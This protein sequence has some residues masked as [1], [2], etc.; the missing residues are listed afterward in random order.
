MKSLNKTNQL[1][2]I[3]ILATVAVIAIGCAIG[4]YSAFA[5]ESSK[6]FDAPHYAE[7]LPMLYVGETM[8]LN[9]AEGDVAMSDNNDIARVSSSGKVRAVSYGKTNISVISG[10]KTQKFTLLV[11][12]TYEG[13]TVVKQSDIFPKSQGDNGFYVYNANNGDIED[14]LEE[15]LSALALMSER[16]STDTGWWNGKSYIGADHFGGAGAGALSFM[17]T[18]SGNYTV[19]YSAWMLDHLRKDPNYFSWN[20]D[21]FTTGIAKKDRSGSIEVL[22]ANIGTKQSVVADETRYQ[23]GSVTVDLNFGDELMMFFCSNGNGD[24]DEVYTEFYLKTNSTTGESS[25]VFDGNVSFP[26]TVTTINDA[27]II[28]VGDE[29]RLTTRFNGQL[30]YSSSDEDVA[31]VTDNGVIVAKSAGTAVITVGD[32]MKTT[33]RVIAVRNKINADDVVVNNDVPSFQGDKNLRVYSGNN[34]DIEND[35]E[36]GLK[37]IPEIEGNYYNAS[38]MAWWNTRTFINS[39]HVFTYGVGILGYTVQ[40]EG[41]YRLDYLSC[42]MPD[43]YNDPNFLNYA[44]CDGYTVGLM[45]KKANGDIEIIASDVNTS[46]SLVTDETRMLVKDCEYDA[47]RGDELCFFWVSNGNGDCDEIYYE[48]SIQ[49][50]YS[51]DDERP[52]E[53]KFDSNSVKLDVNQ[54]KQLSFDVKYD[55]G[56]QYVWSTSDPSVATVSNGKIVGVKSGSCVVTLTVGNAKSSI[57]VYVMERLTYRVGS[58]TDVEF[59]ASTYNESRTVYMVRMNGKVVDKSAYSVIGDKIVFKANYLET[60]DSGSKLIEFFF[61]GDKIVAYLNVSYAD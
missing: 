14:N 13:A 52:T 26:A 48:F 7:D 4:L 29:V 11:K 25:P 9:L 44:Q 19:N 31:T 12:D 3:A 47:G 20:V 28:F 2:L 24:C 43:I 5:G 36:N 41:K 59:N 39:S 40:T 17:A 34:G 15:G 8:Q 53:V 33:S 55:H 50:I 30:N 51:S 49:R 60:L 16:Y 61:E 6:L 23:T 22:V 21:G 46:L 35:L 27:A 56:A 57:V 45:C 42:L 1:R 54:T 10:D 58:K 38:E 18:Y 37:N 32:E